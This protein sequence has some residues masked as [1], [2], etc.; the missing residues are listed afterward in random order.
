[1][2]PSA[3]AWISAHDVG[4]GVLDHVAYAF[5]HDQLDVLCR[6]VSGCE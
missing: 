6:F 4:R 5:Q 3:I 2:S 1:V